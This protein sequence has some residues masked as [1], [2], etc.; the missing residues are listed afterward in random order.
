MK[1][2]AI[3]STDDYDNA[4]ELRVDGKFI[5]SVFDGEPE[6]NNLSRNFSAIYNIP[7]FMEMAYNAGKNGEEFSIERSSGVW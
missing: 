1:I 7:K 5:F 4:Y 2:T 6:D 3:K